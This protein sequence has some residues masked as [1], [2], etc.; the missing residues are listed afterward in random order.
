[1][2][3]EKGLNPAAVSA[4]VR[5]DL[6]NFLVAATP[7]GIERQEAMGQASFVGTLGI[8]PKESPRPQ[9]EKLGFVFGTD[10]DDLFVNVTFPPGWNKKASD[11]SMWSYLLDDKGR[12]RARIFYKAA[13]Y[14][15]SA[16]LTLNRRYVCKRTYLGEDLKPANGNPTRVQ[17]TVHD[18]GVNVALF[19]GGITGYSDY[20]NG[21]AHDKRCKEWLLENFP[22]A[23]DPTAYW[24]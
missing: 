13:F 12:E 15:R 11:H 2:S 23:D 20:A 8:L 5:G 7:G 24:D 10:A 4:A 18:T 9:L 17:H 1:M 14:D 21:D 3:K 16:H 19:D 22:Q 6:E